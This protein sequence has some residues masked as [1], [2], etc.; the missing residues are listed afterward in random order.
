MITGLPTKQFI[1]AISDMLR[2]GGARFRKRDYTHQHHELQL[3]AKH[4]AVTD[5]FISKHTPVAF[6]NTYML[7]LEQG[8]TRPTDE[9]EVKTMGRWGGEICRPLVKDGDRI[10]NHCV[11]GKWMSVVPEQFHSEG[12]RQ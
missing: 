4:I 9:T 6:L 12:G 7:C 3:D 5:V 8:C 2:Q 1:A 10:V 11:I